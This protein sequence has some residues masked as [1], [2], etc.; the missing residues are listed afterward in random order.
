LIGLDLSLDPDLNRSDNRE[1]LSERHGVDVDLSDGGFSSKDIQTFLRALGV[2]KSVSSVQGASG[3]RN[4]NFGINDAIA[5]LNSFNFKTSFGKS[6][7]KK[8]EQ[9]WLPLLAFSDDGSAQVIISF[10]YGVSVKILSNKWRSP[11]KEVEW[12]EFENSFSGFSLLAKKMS[13]E[14][15]RQ[16][17][18]HWF[19]SAFRSSRWLYFQVLLAALISNFLALTTS[20]FTMTVYDRIIPNSA[21][22]SL[23]ALSIGVLFAL[24]CDFIIKMLR[25]RFIDVA[26]KRADLIVSR[27]LFDRILSFDANERKQS[28]GALASIVK[29]FETLREFFTS[30]TLVVIVDLPFVFFFVYVIS[31]IAG[32][33]GYI[34]LICVPLVFIAGLIVQPFLARTVREGMSSGYNKQ[35]ILVET[36]S[37][38]ESVKSS[39]AGPLMK[40]RYQEALSAQSDTSGKAKGLSQFIVNFAASVQQYAQI[41]IIF[42][43]VFLIKDGEITQGA[44]IAAVILGGRAMAPLGQL[45]NVLSRANN[46]LAAY[47]SLSKLFQDGKNISL[48]GHSISRGMLN[49][50]IEFKNVDFQYGEDSEKIVDKMNIKIPCGQKVAI[51][52]KM[53]SGKSTIAKLL[54]NS[55]SPTHGS[56][57]YDG[58]DIRQLDQEDLLRNVG[59]MPQEPWLFSGT[60]RENLQVG[61]PE[62][63]DEDLLK[64]A[65]IGGV[66]EFVAQL[67]E[68]YDTRLREKGAGLSGGQKQA[69]SL[70]R[71][72]LHD[73]NILILDEPTSSMDQESEKKIVE[74]LNLNAKDKTM[75]VITHRNALLSICDRVLV[76]E[77][78]KV[79]ADNTP[80]QLGIKKLAS[81]R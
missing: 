6:K 19:F 55:I 9:T 38:L 21:I 5:S 1:E 68:G 74:N 56:V 43:G 12:D 17:K 7:T 60:I 23:Y 81:S 75:I 64:I 27:K 72:L 53:G 52:G 44:L 73:P 79:I 45:A 3:S 66:D 76:M 50:E 28:T 20:I 24:G 70:S 15:I 41:A 16:R 42:Y 48:E 32:P 61:Y 11:V 37:G 36:L 59:T 78:G 8:W 2:R 26:S 51:V 65:K 35:S 46:A 69:I 58:V 39:G 62:Y 31:L 63:S 14:E 80:E 71:A 54:S 34:P 25:A 57:L 22:E 4:E 29:E 67:P 30:S 13:P 47:K 77:N 40:S 18:G 10:E 49:G 33:L